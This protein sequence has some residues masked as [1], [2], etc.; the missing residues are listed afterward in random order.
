MK[1]AASSRLAKAISR[2]LSPY[3]RRLLRSPAPACFE[4]RPGFAASLMCAKLQLFEMRSK[5]KSRSAVQHRWLAGILILTS[6]WMLN[7]RHYLASNEPGELLHQCG[8]DFYRIRTAFWTRPLLHTSLT[9]M[10]SGMQVISA[11]PRSW[12]N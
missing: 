10:K 3:Q 11:R 2:T 6:I 8:L 5:V 7:L 4:Q 9:A 1:P 12:T